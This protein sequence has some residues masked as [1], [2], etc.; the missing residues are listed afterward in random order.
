MIYSV[1]AV[2]YSKILDNESLS[3]TYIDQ[4]PREIIGRAIYKAT[5]DDATADIT[6]AESL[7][8]WT[9]SGVARSPTLSS[10]NKIYK[11]NSIQTGATGAGTG[12]I[13]YTF[14]SSNFSAFD[15][16]RNWLY[17]GS[18]IE[19]LFSSIKFRI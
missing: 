10:S 14:S 5:A 18:G 9:V 11:N 1:S 8:G 3:D 2:D 16:V 19:D 13:R 15:K 12:K 6:D 17:M 4:Y 7:T